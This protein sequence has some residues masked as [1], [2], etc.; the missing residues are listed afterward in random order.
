MLSSV[1]RAHCLQT[2]VGISPNLGYDFG[3]NCH[4]SYRLNSL[5]GVM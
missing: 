1:G 4:M 5:K 2:P 3:K